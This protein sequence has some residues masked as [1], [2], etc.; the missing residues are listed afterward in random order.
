M[1]DVLCVERDSRKDEAVVFIF[2]FATAGLLLWAAVKPWVG[3][4]INVSLLDGFG[5][6]GTLQLTHWLYRVRR[7]DGA[8]YRCRAMVIAE[9]VEG[10]LG[11]KGIWVY[12][13]CSV[14]V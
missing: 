10:G 13:A 2:I 11:Y 14:G 6:S 4:W 7:N 12:L 8:I 3:K 1:A 5:R 9:S